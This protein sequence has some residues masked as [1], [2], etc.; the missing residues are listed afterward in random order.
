VN[1]S[2]LSHLIIDIHSHF[3]HGSPF[4]CPVSP[5]HRR[6][7]KFMLDEYEYYGIKCGGFST[8]ASV[9]KHYE[10]VIE[11]N[12]YMY[13]TAESDP[14]IY[15]WV[16][17][18]PRQPETYVQAERILKAKKT[19]GIKIHPSCHGYDIEEH[20]DAVFG[21]AN[22][23]KAVVLMHPQKVDKMTAFADRYPDM[24]LIIA[25]LGSETFVEAIR[26]AKHGNIYTDTSAGNF[27]FN[28]ILE[29]AVSQVGSEKLIFATDT[30]SCAYEIGRVIMSR[31]PDEDKR[32]ILYKNAV[33]LFD[34]SFGDIF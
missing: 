26:N 18:D 23:M 8:Y 29:Y 10:C 30:Y 34:R 13:K 33:R 5:I 17:I 3:N 21:F 31:L 15:Q 20:G 6:D 9:L 28:N 24:K 25:H 19:L 32:N 16:V 14:R 7:L 12:E 27:G 22:K 4:D 1:K 11:E 2:A